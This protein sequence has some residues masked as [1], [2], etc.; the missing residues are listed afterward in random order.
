MSG[1]RR[2]VSFG[3]IAMLAIA[4]ITVSV[5]LG[6]MVSIRRDEG[7]LAMDAEKLLESVT[8]L[9]EMSQRHI[10]E[11]IDSQRI[12]VV[13][14]QQP[15]EQSVS[16][17]PVPPVS[18]AL[19][20]SAPTATPEMQ[21]EESRHTVTM[22][23]GGS[24]AIESSVLAGTYVKDS[25]NYLYDDLMSGIASAVHADVN[26]AILKTMLSDGAI[27]DKDLISPVGSVQTLTNA[28]FDTV[29]LCSENALSGGVAVVDET[30]RA[31]S[32]NGIVPCGLYMPENPQRYD[33][34]KINGLQLAVLTYTESLSSASKKAIG[35][36]GA[37]DAMIHLFDQKQAEKD[38]E[39][40]RKNGAQ[41]VLVFMNWGAEDADEAT[42]AQRKTAQALCDAGADILIGYN[43]L[44]VQPVQL[45]TSNQDPTRHMLSAWSLGTLL[46]EDRATRAVV[47]GALLHVQFSYNSTSGSLNFDRIEY[48]PTYVWRQEENG[49]YPYRVIR[50]D[51]SVPEGMIQKQREIF[52]RSLVLIQSTMKKGVA[53][54]R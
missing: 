46:S 42:S 4:C 23:F 13:V 19:A 11:D 40:A 34:L 39:E 50:S 17:T 52:A 51:E 47:S 7:D 12:E 24:V 3:T 38:I 15:A 48:T 41:V 49:I 1:P 6:V 25:K 5:S 18:Q 21:Q 33:L 53:V 29:V 32:S 36:E 22:T 26:F 35:D 37:R 43:S 2:R 28:G 54:E 30:L 16:S 9:M 8:E 10:Y 45:L 31:L 27:A 44:S 20:A 14:T